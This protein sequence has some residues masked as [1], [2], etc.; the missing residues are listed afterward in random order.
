[1][2]AIHITKLRVTNTPK[3]KNQI[4]YMAKFLNTD[5]LKYWIKELI[6]SSEEELVI[7]VPYIKTSDEMFQALKHADD[8]GIETTIIYREN[9]LTPKEKEKIS[10]LKNLNLLHHPN[11]HCKCYFNGELIVICSMNLYA[12]SEKNNREMGVLLHKNSLENETGWDAHSD[13]DELFHDA[14]HEIREIMNGANLEKLNAN[15]PKDRFSINILKTEE[16]RTREQSDE[17]NKYFLNKI[18]FPLQIDRDA[19]YA[20]CN[21]YYDK[22]S[23]TFESKRIAIEINLPEIE[24]KGVHQKWMRTYNEYEFRG[25]KFYWNNHKALLYLYRDNNFD[26][27]KID[28]ERIK[29]KKY[30]QGI[31]LVIAKYRELT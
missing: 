30:K 8:S 19:W 6:T 22:I 4:K 11:V 1:M 16:E 25:F 31:D 12:Y 2:G 18:F 27:S 28:E 17:I 21:N 24:L 15:N 3:T 9:K 13:N 14:I 20:T 7:V 29:Y 10:S 23:V 26:W 5:K